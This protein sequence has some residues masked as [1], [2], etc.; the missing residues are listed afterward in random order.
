M[1]LSAQLYIGAGLNV[2]GAALRWLSTAHPIVCSHVYNRSG[3]LVA[4]LGQV[5][6]ACAQPY[7]T[8]SPTKLASFWF[9]AKERSLCTN[10]AS[11]GEHLYHLYCVIEASYISE[12]PT[13]CQK[14]DSLNHPAVLFHGTVTVNI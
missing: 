6:T 2:V 4:M 11:V 13:V 1:F 3:F 8:Y 10:F 9:G 5:L 14:K 12:Q 7:I